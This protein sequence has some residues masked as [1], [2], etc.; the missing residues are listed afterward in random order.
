[1]RAVR[2]DRFGP[3]DVLR[4]DDIP[5]PIPT[6]GEI[7]IRVRAA[8][9]NALDWK[10]RHGHLRMVPLLERPPRGLGSDFA[11]EVVA[12]ASGTNSRFVGQR[13]FGTLS[14]L[15]RQGSLAEYI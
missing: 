8:S 2:Y 5:E 3:P 15:K 1:M 14:P 9:L 12:V 11:G 6:A 4:V 7:K 13:V 10:I